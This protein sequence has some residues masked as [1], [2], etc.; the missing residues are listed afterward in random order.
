MLPLVSATAPKTHNMALLI[1]NLPSIPYFSDSLVLPYRVAW[2]QHRRPHQRASFTALT[3]TE[4]VP[5]PTWHSTLP[6]TRA[7]RDTRSRTAARSPTIKT[8]PPRASNPAT[9]P[10]APASPAP[11]PPPPSP[12]L[13]LPPHPTRPRVVAAARPE[14][15]YSAECADLYRCNSCNKTLYLQ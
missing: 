14:S 12:P 1:Y 10:P 11:L 15:P 8:P 6:A 2:H 7:G 5:S 13:H 9:A 4:D 3:S